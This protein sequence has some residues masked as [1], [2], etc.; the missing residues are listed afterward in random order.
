M[1][2]LTSALGMAAGAIAIVVAQPAAAAPTLSPSDAI[3]VDALA[4]GLIAKLKAGD[5]TGAVQTFYAGNL[6]VAGKQAQLQIMAGQIS[7]ALALYGPIS[8]CELVEETSH[9]SLVDSRLY[10]CSHDKYVSRWKMMFVKTAHGWTGGTLQFDDKV[11]LGL[12]Q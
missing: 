4:Q 5:G 10:V 2:R 7:S 1:V 12:D 9:G 11:Q 6:L 8:S 3:A